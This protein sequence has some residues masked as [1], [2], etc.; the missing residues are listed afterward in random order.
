MI[1]PDVA[2]ASSTCGDPQSSAVTNAM[3][4]TVTAKRVC[5]PR[6]DRVCGVLMAELHLLHGR[7]HGGIVVRPPAPRRLRYR[8]CRRRTS[9]KCAAPVYEV[10]LGGDETI[11]REVGPSTVTAR[12]KEARH[13]SGRAAQSG[14]RNAPGRGEDRPARSIPTRTC[15]ELWTTP[16]WPWTAPSPDQGTLGGLPHCVRTR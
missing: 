1:G 10:P 14:G 2:A 4:E 13:L 9:R 3:Q 7:G 5:W 12:S 6:G 11:A 8:S 15:V 16:G